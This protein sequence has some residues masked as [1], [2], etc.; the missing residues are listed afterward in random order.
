LRSPVTGH[1]EIDVF[2]NRL[3]MRYTWKA[4]AEIEAKYGDAPNLFDPDTIAHVAAAGLKD[5]HPEYTAERILELSPPLVPFARAVQDALHMAY[6][7]TESIPEAG[8]V[9][10]N[11]FTGGLSRIF[12]LLSRRG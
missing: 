10:K 2:G 1:L 12:K 11:R 3:T 6:F 7:G 5:S 8:P 4:I 9:K